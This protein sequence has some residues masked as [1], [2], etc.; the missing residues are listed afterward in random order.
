MKRNV[1]A[2]LTGLLL[3]A[4]LGACSPQSP[5]VP[6]N[7]VQDPYRPVPQMTASGQG[8]VYLTPDVAYISIGVQ[9]SADNVSAAL[10]DNNA[11]A[12]AIANTLKE[13][14]V[15]EKDI[16]TSAFSV[17]PQQDYAPDGTPMAMKYVVN[18]TVYVTVRDLN[19]LGQMLD[20]VV[21]SGANTIY[22]INFDVENKDA[23]FSEARKMAIDNAKKNAVE[24]AG[25]ADIQLGNLISLNVYQTSGPSPVYSG[26]GGA[27]AAQAQQAP[28]SAGQMMITINADLTYEIQ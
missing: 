1:F 10:N 19:S 8:V 25:A 24:L 9:T 14:G 16:Q 6:A 22:G 3:V 28:V 18:N 2:I 7:P 5:V 13:M 27:M 21:R 20:S 26:K 17:Y 15:D 11:Q 23:A 12:T 4:V